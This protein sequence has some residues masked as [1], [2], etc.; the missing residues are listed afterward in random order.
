MKQININNIDWVK[1]SSYF[2]VFFLTVLLMNQ[3][4]KTNELQLAKNNLNKDVKI[5]ELK[6]QKL[7]YDNSNIQ[8]KL[9]SLETVKQAVKKEIVIVEKKVI[10]EVDKTKKFN[11]NDIAKFYEK[12]Y[13]DKVVITQYGVS[14]KDTIAKMNIIELNTKDGLVDKL[15]LTNKQL[16][17]EEKKVISKD[18][19]IAN[20]GYI[21][22]EKSSLNMVQKQIIK[23]TEKSLKK[24][25]SNKNF[26]KL[27]SGIIL[28]GSAYLLITN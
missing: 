28:A 25:K 1:L 26:W 6:Q 10:V 24:E 19:I 22:D 2:L 5:S 12:R 20:L 8:I 15:K 16:S 3:C 4:D 17:L 11:T 9:D 27:T 13:N 14:L 21:I 23:N 18:T 7:M